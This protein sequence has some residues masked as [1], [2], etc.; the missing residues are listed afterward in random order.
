MAIDE[1]IDEDVVSE[2][3]DDVEEKTTSNQRYTASQEKLMTSIDQLCQV[4]DIMGKLAHRIK[5]QVEAMP[6][7]DKT[8]DKNALSSDDKTANKKGPVL[9]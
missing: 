6:N 5:Y 2:K 7:I 9:H 1:M 4:L 3:E 8:E